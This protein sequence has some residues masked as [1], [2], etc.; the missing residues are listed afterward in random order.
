VN[1][2]LIYLDY[3]A[4]ANRLR[5]DVAA[6]KAVCEVEAPKGGFFPDGTPATLFEGHKFHAF[7][8]GRFSETHPEI[9]YESWTREHYGTWQRE[10]ER[11]AEAIK[12]D[13]EAALKS[14]SWGKFQ[15]M[16]FNHKAAGFPQLQDFVNAMHE[17]E[18]AQLQAFVNFVLHEKLDDELRELRW[19]D[20]ARKYNGP[21][22]R[23]NKYDTKLAAAYASHAA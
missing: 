22:Y 13:R 14:A 11:L 19:A 10:K 7:T 20:F 12:L 21:G 5:C 1:E 16:G 4:A 15:I 6:V 3:L 2:G 9:S 18:G 8:D 23:A 17:S